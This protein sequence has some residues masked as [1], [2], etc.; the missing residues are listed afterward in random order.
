MKVL[1]LFSGTG[2]IP[3]GLTPDD[4]CVSVDISDKF[5]T[6]TLLI[7]VMDWDYANAFPVGYFDVVFAGCPCTEYSRLKDCFKSTKPPNVEEANKVVMRTLEIIEYFKPKFWFI[8][9]PD[10]GKLK[11]QPFMQ[12]LP[13]RRLSY[14]MYGY[15]YRK[16]TRIWTNNERFQPRLC[17]RG[18]CGQVREG[19]HLASIGWKQNHSLSQ[20]YSYPPE[21]VR[22]LLRSCRS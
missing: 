2:S 17:R 21:L 22:E 11:D 12:C 16:L 13:Y 19:R 20:K 18:S 14:C 7:D 15:K 10:T 3:K 6:P 9:N 8:E 1:D 4:E 5:H